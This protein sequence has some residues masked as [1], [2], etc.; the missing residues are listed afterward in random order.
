MPANA[1]LNLLPHPRPNGGRRS[2]QQSRN[3]QPRFVLKRMPGRRAKPVIEARALACPLEDRVLGAVLDKQDGNAHRAVFGGLLKIVPSSPGLGVGGQPSE[4][5]GE[6]AQRSTHHQRIT[7]CVALG[8]ETDD[9]GLS[10][11]R[12]G[13][14]C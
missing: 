9:A 2:L 5:F 1:P 13:F 14:R 6:L 3:L 4:F 8:F 11:E 7:G 12:A 10:E